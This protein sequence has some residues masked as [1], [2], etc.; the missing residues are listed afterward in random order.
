MIR[1]LA[2]DRRK[3]TK[4]SFRNADR[5]AHPRKSCNR[6]AELQMN[7]FCFAQCVI[8]DISTGGAKLLVEASE[9]MPGTFE[10]FDSDTNVRFTAQRVWNRFDIM[11]VKFIAV[12]NE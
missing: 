4:V 9:W 5:R 10:L 12:G 3:T 7:G 1:T 2:R 6:H 11:G 8:K